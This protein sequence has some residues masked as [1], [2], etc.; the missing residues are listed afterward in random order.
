MAY[1]RNPRRRV[2]RGSSVDELRQAGRRPSEE[3][4]ESDVDMP[5]VNLASSSI[6]TAQDVVQRVGNS[7]IGGDFSGNARGELAIDIQIDRRDYYGAILPDR[8]ASGLGALAFGRSVRAAGEY[9]MGFGA[10]LVDADSSVGLGTTVIKAGATRSIAAGT[11]SGIRENSY[12]SVLVGDQSTIFEESLRSILIGG[13]SYVEAN[14]PDSILIGTNTY[15]KTATDGAVAVG[16]YAHVSSGADRG[17]VI[18]YRAKVDVADQA[19][20]AATSFKMQ[21]AVGPYPAYT[22][23]YESVITTSEASPVTGNL[24]KFLDVDRVGDAGVA[25]ADLGS[26]G[27]TWMGF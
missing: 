27:R 14:S 13:E 12:A 17:V 11:D 21:T 4:R 1:T 8:V 2:V 25:A 19:V 10:A 23:T 9:S 22:R 26:M 6:G 24:A 18:G 5:F 20:I 15:I 7:I 3:L 16:G